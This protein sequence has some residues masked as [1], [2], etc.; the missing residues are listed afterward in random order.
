MVGKT[1]RLTAVIKPRQRIEVKPSADTCVRLACY[2]APHLGHVIQH[3]GV[4]RS[5]TS[6]L[7][8]WKITRPNIAMPIPE[9][10]ALFEIISSNKTGIN[11]QFLR[12]FKI[13]KSLRKALPGSMDSRHR[14]QF[15]RLSISVP[16]SGLSTSG[17]EMSWISAMRWGFYR[18]RTA[19]RLTS[20]ATNP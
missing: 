18:S 17:H 11:L 20:L 10:F 8:E 2:T 15:G 9:A 1:Y 7:P 16:V 6:N 3:G 4:D 5:L 14:Y 19:F 12:T 13:Q